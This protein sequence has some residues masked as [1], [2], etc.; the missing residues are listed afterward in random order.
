MAGLGVVLAVA[1]AAVSISMGVASSR[2]QAKQARAQGKARQAMANYNAQVAENKQTAA[3][4]AA[5][6]EM[7]ATREKTRRQKSENQRL[8]DQQ[9]TIQAKSGGDFSGSA[10]LVDADQLAEMKLQELDIMHQGELRAREHKITG[11]QAGA[12]ATGSLF[13]GE[14]SRS[15]ANQQ[16]KGYIR[17][18]WYNA[19]S[20]TAQFVGSMGSQYAKGRAAKGK[21]TWF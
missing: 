20:E 19:A 4:Q 5:K 14:M 7:Q 18:G 15:L 3:N 21:S 11:M 1:G 13:Q 16:A 10:L 9:L 17:Q 2:Q 12:E 8:R 6:A